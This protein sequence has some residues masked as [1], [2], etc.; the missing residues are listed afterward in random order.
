MNTHGHAEVAEDAGLPLLRKFFG[1][2]T[3]KSLKAMKLGNW[4][5]DV[6]QTIDPVA[7]QGAGNAS[8]KK[9]DAVAAEVHKATAAL[10]ENLT[11][12]VIGR[13]P[14][15]VQGSAIQ[16]LEK[17]GDLIETPIEDLKSRIHSGIDVLLGSGGKNE[18]TSDLGLFFRSIFLVVGYFKF[19]HPEKAGGNSRMDFKSF[20]AVFG[21]IGDAP[22]AQNNQP[23]PD[24]AG[25]FTQYYP[26]EH[27][28]RPERLK[29][30]GK[31][32]EPPIYEPGP[33]LDG[34]EC[35]GPVGIRLGP[36][37]PRSRQAEPRP[38]LYYF[39]RDDIE[40]TAGLLAE[41]DQELRSAIDS[42]T[43]SSLWEAMTNGDKP[44]EATAKLLRSLERSPAWHRTLAKLGHAVHQVEDFFA[45]SDWIEIATQLRGP[46]YLN[47]A[48]APKPTKS[49]PP[50]VAREL[51]ERSYTTFSRR[52]KRHLTKAKPNWKDHPRETWIVTGS[53]DFRD[54]LISLA[55]LTE[56]LWGDHV[57][58][59]WES[60]TQS[61]Q[62]A[63][64]ALRKSSEILDQVRGWLQ[65]SFDLLTNPKRAM[66]DLDNSVAQAWKFK[67]GKAV[68]SI[69]GGDLSKTAVEIVL[70]SPLLRRAPPAIQAAA[71]SALV[72]GSKAR[73]SLSL[74]EAIKTLTKFL[75]GPVHWL[76][77]EQPLN[78]P[79]FFLH[80]SRE[81]IYD[82]IGMNRIGCHSLLAKDHGGE[83]LY[84][85]N[86]ACATG[87]HYYVVHTLLQPWADG[88]KPAIDWLALLEFFLQNPAAALG[89][90]FEEKQVDI[91]V[92][93]I[94]EVRP[95]EQ[96]D[97]AKPRYSL[98]KQYRPTAID[99]AKFNWRT[100]ADANFLTGGLP[101][102]E[103]QRII[104]LTLKTT[105]KGVPV[106]P[107]NYAF[108]PGV[109][110]VIPD[111][112]L[113]VVVPVMKK[114]GA[115]PWFVTVM[116]NGWK[117]FKGEDAAGQPKRQPLDPYRPVRIT[118]DET[119][120][121]I[122][123]ARTK[124]LKA[125]QTYRPPSSQ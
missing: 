94:H 18:R 112:K 17:L 86:K 55:H 41:V 123:T 7:Y 22:G 114:N 99:P 104:N 6:S 78:L 59:P 116:D 93:V 118:K 61:A 21:N 2:Q 31:P 88:K 79:D 37:S 89:L 84:L 111:Q 85:P 67:I 74:Y 29:P 64:E 51:L 96:L 45:H 124:R 10:L 90:T 69:H 81:V 68:A 63:K 54:T 56:E 115:E 75:T 58:D 95:S 102:A 70:Q 40:M 82:Y 52:L 27:L 19:V 101:E 117:V 20:L 50:P 34:V 23:T 122:T 92:S 12:A 1:G 66:A 36:R 80:W 38:D 100:I 15:I 24:Q 119:E 97:H 83:P 106:T 9:A 77:E 91:S 46:E 71:E 120:L 26:H 113:R 35:H 76:L 39:L 105:K 33:Q 109:K 11:S 32:G 47:K 14:A 87:V 28:D 57:P 30:P 48:L 43:W 3:M 103:A 5:T 53:F 107:P 62:D 110:I 125:R 49:I 8:K 73:S 98:T 72:L 16:E 65:D 108:K 44:N 121:L 4:L 25:S 60:L 42:K 13:L